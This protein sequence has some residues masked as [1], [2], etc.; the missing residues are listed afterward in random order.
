ML[1]KFIERKL[2]GAKYK[3]LKD[4]TYL[5]EIPGFR[6]VWANSEKLEDCR[7]ELREV[8]ENWLLLKVRDKEPVPGFKI[9]FD[10]R[11]L[12]RSA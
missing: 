9:R 12:V 3:L 7:D 6:G 2:R 4:G 11:Q 5:G 1:S 10:R 8:L